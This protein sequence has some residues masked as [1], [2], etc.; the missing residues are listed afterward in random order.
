MAEGKSIPVMPAMPAL[1]MGAY[2]WGLVVRRMLIRVWILG[3]EVSSRESGWRW[4]W[5]EAEGAKVAMWERRGL[6]GEVFGGVAGG[7]EAD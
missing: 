1:R 6:S 5:W 3:R 7:E 2:R 4:I